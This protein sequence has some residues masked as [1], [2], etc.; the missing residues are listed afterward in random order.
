M[1]CS[2]RWSRQLLSEFQASK[3][4]RDQGFLKESERCEYQ[5]A[6]RSSEFTPRLAY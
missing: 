5:R 4:I 3:K 1:Y 2:R 6:R